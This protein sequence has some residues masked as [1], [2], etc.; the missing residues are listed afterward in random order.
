MK[1]LLKSE[2]CGSREQYIGPTCVAE[3]WLKSQIVRLKK[4][5]KG[6]KTQM[7]NVEIENLHSCTTGLKHTWIIICSQSHRLLFAIFILVPGTI[8]ASQ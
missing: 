5:K 6:Q 4:K 2:V 8:F 1:K 3:K 7:P